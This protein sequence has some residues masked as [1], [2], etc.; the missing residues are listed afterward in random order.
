MQA[1]MGQS[2][3]KATQEAELHP[4]KVRQAKETSPAKERAVK[5]EQSRLKAKA[6]A[7]GGSGVWDS[8]AAARVRSGISGTI[9]TMMENTSDVDYSDWLADNPALVSKAYEIAQTMEDFAGGTATEHA[10]ATL[11]AGGQWFFDEQG[12]YIEY[13]HPQTGEK[14]I[15]DADVVISDLRKAGLM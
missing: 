5:L 3:T 9:K 11:R 13:P 7:A 12:P 2:A 8:A 15:K 14:T 6:A 4:E 10:V 1:E